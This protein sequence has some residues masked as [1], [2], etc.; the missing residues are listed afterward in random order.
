MPRHPF[1]TCAASATRGQS[2]DDG[3]SSPSCFP[4]ACPPGRL[5][6]LLRDGRGGARP[7]ADGRT[8][9]ARR[10]LS[11][12]TRAAQTFFPFERSDQPAERLKPGV[13]KAAG[14]VE[15][16]RVRAHSLSPLVRRAAYAARHLGDEPGRAAYLYGSDT[17]AGGAWERT[18]PHSL[19]SR[20]SCSAHPICPTHQPCRLRVTSRCVALLA[21]LGG[22]DS[23]SGQPETGLT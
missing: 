19:P 15:T 17:S 10:R 12:G 5:K 9:A 14:F 16:R 23:P 3:T 11:H 7:D 1:G 4:R 6:R 22:V 18:P 2:A 8:S 20:T 21:E 13:D